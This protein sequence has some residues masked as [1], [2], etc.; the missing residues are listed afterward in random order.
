MTKTIQIG[1]DLGTTNSVVAINK[2][3]DISII[4]NLEG[5]E[6]TPS[7]FGIDKAKNYV[8]GKR[9]YEKLFQSS[10]NESSN[11]KAEVKRLMG[12][13]DVFNFERI[14]KKMNAE[15]ISAEIL[16][17]L[18]SFALKKD[19]EL[20]TEGV[21]ITIPA[22]FSTSESEATTRAG[23][24]AG[25]N[26]VVLL[27]EPIAAAIAH[28]FSSKKNKNCIIYDFG[29]GTF[30]VALISSKD[31]V[32]SVRSHNG[33]NYLGG[34]D[35]DWEIVDK[36]IVP[37]LLEKYNF[38]D[39]KRSNDKYKQLFI[40]LKYF[41]E[42]AK[43][44]LSESDRVMIEIDD[45]G[46]DENGEDVYMTI[47]IEK[48]EFEKIIDPFIEKSLQL[49][50]KTIDEAGL[51]TSSIDSVVLVGGTTL[52]PYISEK[53][54]NL[55]N[56]E[57]DTSIDPFTVVSR[58]AAIY[59]SGQRIKN[60]E[61]NNAD[62]DK[63]ESSKKIKI[64][65]E[66][67]S[68][69]SEEFITGQVFE[70]D[71]NK[72]YFIQIQSESN[73]YLSNKISLTPE[74]KFK[75]TV[76]LEKEKLNL[77]NI[78]L[79]DEEG[80]TIPL[81]QESFSISQGLSTSGSPIPH[82]IGLSVRNKV[83]VAGKV[84]NSESFDIFFKRNS[85]LPLEATKIYKTVTDVKKGESQNALPINIYEGES[86][87]PNR[88]DFICSL[89]I[90]GENV[91]FDLPA[92]TTVEISISVDESRTVSVSAYIPDIDKTFNARGSKFDENIK[93]EE[94]TNEVEEELERVEKISSQCTDSEK[95]EI[96][97]KE[98]LIKTSIEN[99]KNDKDEK[100]K[101]GKKIKEFQKYIDELEI[102]N[103]I[104]S[105]ISAY[106]NH[107]EVIEK[108]LYSLDDQEK[109]DMF[110]KIK[111]DGNRAIKENDAILLSNINNQMFEII[112]SLFMQ[113]IPFWENQLN[114]LKSGSFNFIDELKAEDL[115][116]K[117]NIS[118]EE[119]NLEILKDSVIKL[120][121]LM[122]KEEANK[123]I[124]SLSGISL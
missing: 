110:L 32:L 121:E 112:R 27:Q 105:L 33:D 99:G 70:L 107:V 106:N 101:A 60:L 98:L 113:T 103:N 13:D 73:Y 23:K 28:G 96:K 17:S 94:L 2:N 30:D 100:R 66:S 86:L 9:A 108:V 34:K 44:Y 37:N 48:N 41:A 49:C 36:I 77:F 3:S 11:Y 116:R 124:Q 120:F 51:K 72:K 55:F 71:K 31:G 61:K 85:I 39:F 67:L 97:E 15:E 65:H 43:K 109:K 50:Q 76:S 84:E 12:T 10:S 89:K 54:K 88:N 82:S 46:K 79:L 68:S 20:N 64:N 25:F 8:V 4:K 62:F 104:E 16:K 102:K 58:G 111:N 14:N 69:D 87:I 19:K 91:P 24:L 117:A 22:Y 45:I 56:I 59:A 26:T 5:I 95:N 1:I 80:G 42:T 122:P 52:I 18:K 63:S 118:L 21:V 93:I 83:I 35:L 74:G 81:T 114:I 78:S 29:G 75:D 6:Y 47:N 123:N 40:R 90:S 92:N 119:E 53:L 7:V 115:F 38:K 57:I